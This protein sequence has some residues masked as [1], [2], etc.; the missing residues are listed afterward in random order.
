MPRKSWENQFSRI[1]EKYGITSGG[2]AND[3]IRTRYQE[4]GWSIDSRGEDNNKTWYADRSTIVSPSP[5]KGRNPTVTKED[6]TLYELQRKFN[7]GQLH[8]PVWQ[9]GVLKWPPSKQEKFI[10]DICAATEK[11]GDRFLE[12]VI[13]L[14]KHPINDDESEDSKIFINDGLQRISMGEV[15][16]KRLEATYGQ[17]EAQR[18][19][20]KIKVATMTWVECDADALEQ[21]RRVN[22]GTPLTNGDLSK[23]VLAGHQSYPSWIPV[24]TY[25]EDMIRNIC[26]SRLQCRVTLHSFN[27]VCE[28]FSNEDFKRSCMA[29]LARWLGR[30]RRRNAYEFV[31]RHLKSA[32]AESGYLV[33][34]K[35]V[36]QMDAMSAADAKVKI[37]A[38]RKLFEVR[39]T[40]WRNELDSL[41]EGNSKGFTPALALF[42]MATTIHYENNGIEAS[43]QNIWTKALVKGTKGHSHLEQC[44]DKKAIV[45]TTQDLRHLTPVEHAIETYGVKP[46]CPHAP[47]SNTKVGRIRIKTILAPGN[48]H[49]HFEPVS[50]TGIDSGI[51]FPESSSENRSRGAY[52]VK[53]PPTVIAV[54][55][56]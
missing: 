21:F 8:Q 26:E 47:S 40:V 51:T 19:L 24:F 22:Q 43:R 36:H 23:T 14:Y 41:P 44:N 13:V 9:R 30:E 29:M 49:S 6:T 3:R 25:M 46:I 56:I 1:K 37:D 52:P 4:L 16:Y 20:E 18:R 10:R 2:D 45:I 54:K 32:I 27:Q 42:L 17:L 11:S 38:L 50:T 55:H 39:T 53:I 7:L 33:E 35:L 15:L 31:P 28:K 34:T 48:D 12:S 5:T